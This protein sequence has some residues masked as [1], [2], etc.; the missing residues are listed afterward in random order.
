MVSAPYP[1]R[2]RLVIDISRPSINNTVKIKN[3]SDSPWLIQAWLEDNANHPVPKSVFPAIARVESLDNNFIRVIPPLADL[4]AD[5]ENFY[6][7][8]IK[9]IPGNQQNTHATLLIP[10]IYRIKVFVRS[11][12]LQKYSTPNACQ[13]QWQYHK[14]KMVVK[15]PTPYY[16]SLSE[17]SFGVQTIT[18]AADNMILPRYEQVFLSDIPS[19][20]VTQFSIIDANGAIKYYTP[21]CLGI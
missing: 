1:D 21:E 8:N 4:A 11:A 20:K 5:V 12:A 6:W 7:L 3:D 19:H 18:V 15:N 14:N 2:T 17:V 13:L 9:I 16:Y 10:I